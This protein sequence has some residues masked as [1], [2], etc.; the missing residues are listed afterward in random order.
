MEEQIILR[1][2]DR[3]LSGF[4]KLNE[5]AIDISD[6]SYLEKKYAHF[7]IEGYK[8]SGY[9]GTG[10]LN[11]YLECKVERVP[12]LMYKQR[13]LIPLVFR[14]SEA[15]LKL[16][17]EEYRMEA[18]FYLLDWHLNYAPDKVVVK[19]STEYTNQKKIIIDSAYLVFRMTEIFDKAGYPLSN[20][21][22]IDQFEEWNMIYRL[23]D[24]QHPGR[25]SRVFDRTS[26]KNISELRLIIDLIKMRYPEIKL[27][28]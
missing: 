1:P 14:S 2:F 5:L 17:Q 23:I 24:N 16:F 9:V 18:F 7:G 28:I 19:K 6:C 11:H 13:Y 12:M 26:T 21:Q 15:S 27:S 20:F 10:Y 22:T 3:I 25:H 8:I 4:Q